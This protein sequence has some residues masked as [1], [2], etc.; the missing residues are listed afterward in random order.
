LLLNIFTA[1]LVPVEV[2]KTGIG[3]RRSS[4]FS[5]VAVLCCLVVVEVA[6]DSSAVV[7]GR[8]EIFYGFQ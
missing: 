8:E 4:L 2:V 3:S 7:C 1:L 5:F 6:F